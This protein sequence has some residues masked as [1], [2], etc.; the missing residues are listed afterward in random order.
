MSTPTAAATSIAAAAAA[1]PYRGRL[2]ESYARAF[3]HAEKKSDT[4]AALAYDSEIEGLQP[5]ATNM[6]GGILDGLVS[7]GL[8]T[9]L[10]VAILAITHI[11]LMGLL[12][13][14]D[15][16]VTTLINLGGLF[17]VVNLMYMLI[18]RIFTGSSLG[19]WA[20]DLQMGSDDDRQ[21]IAYFFKL[22]WRQVVLAATAFLPFPIL[23]FMMGRDILRPLSGLQLYRRVD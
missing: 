20:F 1:S 9:V 15:M 2:D 21:T 4:D 6:T 18:T 8:A 12:R 11:N 22:I 23:S 19:E 7:M 17:L 3:P 5:L 14:S 13:N 16:R 10:L